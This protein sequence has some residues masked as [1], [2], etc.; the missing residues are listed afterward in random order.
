MCGVFSDVYG[1]CADVFVYV[2]MSRG[3][4]RCA[5]VCANVYGV[6]ADV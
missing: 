4:C 6:F 2:Q 1:V 5:G 3:M